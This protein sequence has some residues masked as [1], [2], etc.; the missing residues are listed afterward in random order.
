MIAVNAAP[1][2]GPLGGQ[3][4]LGEVHLGSRFMDNIT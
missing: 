1:P 2:D 4:V 3:L